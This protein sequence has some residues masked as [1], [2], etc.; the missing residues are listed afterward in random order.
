[1][2]SLCLSFPFDSAERE[3]V[4]RRKQA[5]HPLR[6]GGQHRVCQSVRFGLE[7]PGRMLAGAAA[8]ALS[9]TLPSGCGATTAAGLRLHGQ[10]LPADGGPRVQRQRGYRHCDVRPHLELGRLGSHRHVQSLLQHEPVQRRHIELGHLQ[11][12]KHEGDV[13]GA[14][15]AC[16]A[17][18]HR[19]W[20]LNARSLRRH[21]PTRFCI[22]APH[23]APLPM[24]PFQ[25]GRKRRRSTSC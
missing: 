19:S 10:G 24:L 9:A 15:R 1:M 17:S 6:M 4:V 20:V 16:P 22:L 12:D 3:R 13:P 5:P 7:R 2:S 23:V 25:L 8:A 14:F 21:R 11:R 18:H